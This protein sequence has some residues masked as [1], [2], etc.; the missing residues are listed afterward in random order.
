MSVTLTLCEFDKN[1]ILQL[2]VG[3]A[4]HYNHFE[5]LNRLK[6]VMNENLMYD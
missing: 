2:K 5:Y 3:N 6:L 1:S 4:N